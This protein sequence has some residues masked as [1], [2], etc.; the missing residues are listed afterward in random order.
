MELKDVERAE[1]MVPP[2][3][4]ELLSED[5]VVTERH[6]DVLR[7]RLRYACLLMAIIVL[8]CFVEVTFLLRPDVPW[9]LDKVYLTTAL[10]FQGLQAI[11]VIVKLKLRRS[12]AFL[13]VLMDICHWVFVVMCFGG[14]IIIRTYYILSFLA[15][16]LV[17][18]VVLRVFMRND[19]LLTV[20]ADRSS[21]PDMS[22]SSVNITFMSFALLAMTRIVFQLTW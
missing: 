6:E 7:V 4:I 10:I 19:C 16:I 13:S 14:V 22:G 3:Q 18:G 21:F 2:P 15:F 20:V 11:T 12:N 5:V 8:F 17:F 1:P 9:I